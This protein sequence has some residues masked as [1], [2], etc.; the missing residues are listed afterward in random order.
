MKQ[1]DPDPEVI[2]ARSLA[3]FKQWQDVARA[4]STTP[5][6][7]QFDTA[8]FKKMFVRAGVSPQ[9]SEG[10]A[11]VPSGSNFATIELF[12]VRQ[13]EADEANLTVTFHYDGLALL[14]LQVEDPSMEAI[15]ATYF[16]H[17]LI[18]SCMRGQ[19]SGWVRSSH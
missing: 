1:P 14:V 12:V 13:H 9:P 5:L 2:Q 18:A 6:E 15:R 10:S 4:L 17:D 11:R 8:A 16:A 7:V 19:W 3:E